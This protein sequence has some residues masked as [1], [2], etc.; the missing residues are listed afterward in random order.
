MAKTLNFRDDA[1]RNC[2][3]KTNEDTSADSNPGRRIAAVA[4]KK[5]L[6]ND[7]SESKNEGPN[8]APDQE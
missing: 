5:S 2:G 7:E 3:E 1:L 8:T 4:L 6:G